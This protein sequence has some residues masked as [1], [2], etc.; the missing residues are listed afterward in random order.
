M[1][2][3]ETQPLS[4]PP[5]SHYKH[6]LGELERW[7]SSWEC[8]QFFQR[9]GVQFPAPTQGLTSSLTPAL[10]DLTLFWP[11]RVLH[12]R[13]T[14]TPKIKPQKIQRGFFFFFV[15]M[16]THFHSYYKLKK[17]RIKIVSPM[18]TDTISAKGI[19]NW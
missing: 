15:S 13:G 3:S 11:W 12:T 7:L 18:F 2:L 1:A 4:G 16:G 19:S 10:E 14:D 6:D 5:F 17:K 9:T 8:Q